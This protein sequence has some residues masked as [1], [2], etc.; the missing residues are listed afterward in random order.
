GHGAA[1]VHRGL[2]ALGLELV[3]DLRQ[4]LDLLLLEIQLVGEKPQRPAHAE[5]AASAEVV[6]AAMPPA[7]CLPRAGLTAF[8]RSRTFAAAVPPR[9]LPPP[10]HAWIHCF[11]RLAGARRARRGL[12]TWAPC[13]TR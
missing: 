10:E 11:L 2:G 3:E 8:V 6:T 9:V 1:I 5:S 12:Q 7:S 13:L 4:L